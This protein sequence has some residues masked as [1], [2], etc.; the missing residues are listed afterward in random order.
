MPQS[1]SLL[2]IHRDIYHVTEMTEVFYPP[3]D[4]FDAGLLGVA[5]GN[6]IYWEVS[7]NPQGKAARTASNDLAILWRP[8][9]DAEQK[10]TLQLHWSLSHS[11]ALDTDVV[12]MISQV[13][14]L[15]SRSRRQVW[16]PVEV[17]FL[18]TVSNRVP[19]LCLSFFGHTLRESIRQV[20]EYRGLM[21][22]AQGIEPWT[23][24]V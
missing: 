6:E 15:A 19:L 1:R 20:P 24:P 5:D 13:S 7:G 21:V 8:R 10:R 12:V 14:S 3:M 18:P 23:S 9:C 11:D 17:R 16:A 4:P 22:G 2:P